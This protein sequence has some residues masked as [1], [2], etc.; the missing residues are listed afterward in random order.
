MKCSRNGQARVLSP[1]ELDR[2]IQCLP[3]GTHQVLANLMRRTGSRVSEARQLTWG[4][5]TERAVLLPKGITK[6]K[7]AS[8]EIPMHPDLWTVMQRW[9]SEW[10]TAMNRPPESSDLVFPGRSPEWPIS[11]Q[12][13][14]QQLKVAAEKARLSGVA[15]HS[16][17]R[18]AL[19]AASAQ[20]IPLAHLRSLSGHKSLAAL[21]RYLETTE[22]DKV[23]AAM[24]FA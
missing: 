9:R 22:E 6:A 21:Q 3:A 17:R 7:L 24:A 1:S 16:F 20:G 8:R 11:R 4:C 10:A 5:I 14:G 23:K 19:S 15:T 13:F 2:L 18:S 12:A